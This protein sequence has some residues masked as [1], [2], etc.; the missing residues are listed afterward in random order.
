MLFRTRVFFFASP[1]AYSPANGSRLLRRTWVTSTRTDDGTCSSTRV[2]PSADTSSK[3]RRPDD[4]RPPETRP[5]STRERERPENG[6]RRTR[7]RSSQTAAAADDDGSASPDPLR[8]HTHSAH[9]L[10]PSV[11]AKC[12]TWCRQASAVAAVCS[13]RF[14][15]FWW[16]SPRYHAS[17]PPA[18]RQ[19][20][21]RRYRPVTPSPRCTLVAASDDSYRRSN[22]VTRWSTIYFRW[23]PAWR[24]ST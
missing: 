14:P 1:G 10:Y 20:R 13:S 6:R 24:T 9:S 18:C 17:R 23:A 3:L 11:R 21:R 19:L 16:S 4:R 5:R 8:Y 2:I 22:R 15:S 12:R 7:T